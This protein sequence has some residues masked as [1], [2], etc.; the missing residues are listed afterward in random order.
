MY[1]KYKTHEINKPLEKIIQ[2][3][4]TTTVCKSSKVIFIFFLFFCFFKKSAATVCLHFVYSLTFDSS[5][6]IILLIKNDC[7]RRKIF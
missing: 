4:Q 1:S 5:K 2:T 6:L 3:L 7:E